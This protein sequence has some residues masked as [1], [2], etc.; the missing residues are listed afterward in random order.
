M[1]LSFHCLFCHGYE[2]RDKFSAGVLAVEDLA[3]VM[4]A[5]QF[6]RNALQLTPNGVTIYM[7]GDKSLCD[8]LTATLGPESKIK[9]NYQ[10][11]SRLEKGPNGAEVIVHFSDGSH[12]VEAFLAHKPKTQ[13]T[14]TLAQQ[15]GLE[16]TAAGDIK[17]T[18]PFYQT[19]VPGIFTGGDTSY[20]V[21][22][23][24][25]ALFTGAAAAAG[26]SAQ[27]QAESLGHKSMV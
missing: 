18:P 4:P 3:N 19:S 27:L 16:L 15:L 22:I 11:I 17:T 14:G 9:S 8:S 21:K 7:N 2:E 26:V 10:A 20:P 13:L 12:K 24:S 1:P 5:L 25:N 6:A 23:V